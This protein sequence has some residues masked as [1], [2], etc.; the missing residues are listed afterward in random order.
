MIL[1]RTSGTKLLP[2]RNQ[3]LDDLRATALTDLV[4]NN[5]RLSFY[6]SSGTISENRIVASLLSTLHHVQDFYVARFDRALLT[7]DGLTII[8][9]A[10]ATRDEIANR[11]H[12]DLSVATDDAHVALARRIVDGHQRIKI[13]QSGATRLLKGAVAA[14]Y[15]ALDLLEPIVQRQL[16]E[17][18]SPPADIESIVL[19]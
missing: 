14:G 10:G 13:R 4:L 18:E 15:F 11:A 9:A 5:G 19:F 6:E 3:S 2:S 12:F 1:R 7:G 16:A 17:D 8:D